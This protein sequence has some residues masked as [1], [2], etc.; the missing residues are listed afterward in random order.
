MEEGALH[1]LHSTVIPLLSLLGFFFPS[2]FTRMFA[3]ELNYYCINYCKLNSHKFCCVFVAG[4]LNENLQADQ[5]LHL[6]SP[7]KPPPLVSNDS[8]DLV[9]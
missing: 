4:S 7:I 5:T 3:N 2:H 9:Q 6:L 1:Y 8:G